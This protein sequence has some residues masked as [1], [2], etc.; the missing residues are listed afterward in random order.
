MIISIS[1]AETVRA[2]ETTRERRREDGQGRA[3]GKGREG[4]PQRR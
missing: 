4:Q 1:V 2:D 3:L